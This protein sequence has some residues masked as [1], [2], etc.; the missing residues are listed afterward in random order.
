M[1]NAKLLT[2]AVLAAGCAQAKA[3]PPPQSETPRIAWVDHNFGVVCYAL[4]WRTGQGT[5][6]TSL[7]CTHVPSLQGPD[8][9]VDY[10]KRI[11]KGR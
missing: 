8:K 6:A 1:T 5:T 11:E 3:A 4:D 7:S 10:S 2:V 9:K